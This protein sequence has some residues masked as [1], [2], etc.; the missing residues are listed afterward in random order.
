M[1]IPKWAWVI[2]WIVIVLIIL[3]ITKF[4]FHA[5][6]DGVGVSQGLVH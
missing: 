1:N 3:V 5:G 2:I 6:P 4:N